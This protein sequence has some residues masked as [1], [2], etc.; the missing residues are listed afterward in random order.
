MV[1]RYKQ[2]N[3]ASRRLMRC[4]GDTSYCNGCPYKNTARKKVSLFNL[5][6]NRK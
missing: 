2:C 3:K 4:G 1:N 6:G 5:G